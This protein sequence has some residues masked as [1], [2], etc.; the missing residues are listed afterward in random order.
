VNGNVSVLQSYSLLWKRVPTIRRPAEAPSVLPRERAQRSPAQQMGRFQLSGVMSQ[1]SYFEL[2]Y[3]SGLN[4]FGLHGVSSCIVA[5]H[6][7]T[8]L[9]E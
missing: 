8:L 4:D 5:V 7:Y 9:N 6:V 3:E 2:S 1:Y